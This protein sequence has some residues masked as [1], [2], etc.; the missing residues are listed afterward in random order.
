[1]EP[2]TAVA[3]YGEI[4]MPA[5]SVLGVL[6]LLAVTLPLA[7]VLGWWSGIRHRARRLSDTEA[8]ALVGETT[9]GAILAILGL[10]LAFSFGSAV[11]FQ[12]ANKAGQLDEAAALGTAFLRADM[13][14]DPAARA[15]QEALLAYAETRVPAQDGRLRSE[16][17]TVAFFERTL[18]AQAVLWPLTLEATADPTPPAL[19]TFVAGAVNEVIDMH[20]YR[21]GALEAPVADHANLM[22]LATSVAALF[23]LGN[24][25]GIQGSALTW[26]TF[27]LSG[28]LVVVMGTILDLQRPNDGL[29]RAST[30]Y[31]D[32]AIFDMRQALENG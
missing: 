27:V 22:L 6:V 17:E 14:E 28:F 26:R 20:L 3:V 2:T 12:Q 25:A 29:I 32:S 7:A 15:L 21:I 11:A 30:L 24:R 18:Q 23:L 5:L 9:L 19:R 31:L 4:D 10:L 13:L 1:M 8:S 16:E